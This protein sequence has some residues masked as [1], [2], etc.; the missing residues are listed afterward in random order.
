MEHLSKLIPHPTN[1][2]EHAKQCLA[3]IRAMLAKPEK[4]IPKPDRIV[5][6]DDE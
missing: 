2:S 3:K 1:P 4:V 5:G 6:E